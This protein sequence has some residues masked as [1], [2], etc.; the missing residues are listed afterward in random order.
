MFDPDEHLL[1]E[2]L[3]DMRPPTR[4]AAGICGVGD[5]HNGAFTIE[6]RTEQATGHSNIELRPGHLAGRR[7][8]DLLEG[9]RIVTGFTSPNSF[10]IRQAYG[11]ERSPLTYIPSPAQPDP[12]GLLLLSVIEGLAVIQ[13]HTPEQILVPEPSQITPEQRTSILDTARLLR[14]EAITGTWSTLGQVH[15]HPGVDVN[16]D[17]RF[18]V[19]LYQHLT[20]ELPGRTLVLPGFQQTDLPAAR[21]DPDSRH[22]HDDHIDVRFVPAG[23]DLV[24]FIYAPELPTA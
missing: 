12:G 1:A 19:R 9:L 6:M 2:P 4:G 20:V 17:Q 23:S 21:A 8:H 15:M 14:G 18:A 13:D 11:P 22:D 3:I 16:P 7:P 5:D 10:R 24:Q